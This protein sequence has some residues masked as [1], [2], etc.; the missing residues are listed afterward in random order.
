[1]GSNGEKSDRPGQSS[2][3]FELSPITVATLIAATALCLYWAVIF[4][5][6]HTKLPPGL[7]PGNSDKLM[8]FVA[9]A[10]LGALLIS[11]RAT[12]GIYPWSSL[13]KRWAI[14]AAYGAFDE[15]TQLLV[16]RTADVRDW[17]A[18]ITGAALGLGLVTLVL[19]L[20]RKS[21]RQSPVPEVAADRMVS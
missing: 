9:Y 8:H 6:T 3:G 15:V 13:W 14:L 4:Y 21:A 19:W 11:V 16:N 20:Y 7:L 12:R 17:L 2:N 18:D 5:A 10:V 1:M